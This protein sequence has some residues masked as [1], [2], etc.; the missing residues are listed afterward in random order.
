MIASE[1]KSASPDV[2]NDESPAVVTKEYD[3]VR[4]LEKTGHH[5]SLL[6]NGISVGVRFSGIPD[7]CGVHVEVVHVLDLRNARLGR[8][9]TGMKTHVL[10]SINKPL[11]VIFNDLSLTNQ[12]VDKS[13]RTLWGK[14]PLRM[15]APSKAAMRKKRTSMIHETRTVY[16][17]TNEVRPS[18]DLTWL[19]DGSRI[20]SINEFT[21]ARSS[22][23]RSALPEIKNGIDTEKWDALQRGTMTSFYALLGVS[24]ASIASLSIL[25]AII[26]QSWLFPVSGIL[27]IAS[28]LMTAYYSIIS[29]RQIGLFRTSLQ[30][31]SAELSS[32]GDTKRITETLKETH[33]H[34]TIINDLNF[35]IPTL[36]GSAVESLIEG[37][38]NDAV[39]YSSVVLDEC[40]R[41][42]PDGYI[43][44]DN[45]FVA[46]RG[47]SKF[48]GLF[49]YLGVHFEDG[50]EEAL[51]LA[52]SAISGHAESPLTGDEVV[53]HITG[54]SFALFNSGIL[55]PQLKDSIDD[56]LNS[57]S[58]EIYREHLDSALDD[59]DE[60]VVEKEV[61]S[62]IDD[63]IHGEI[64]STLE[65]IS[66]ADD[67]DSDDSEVQ[68][69]PPDVV[70]DDDEEPEDIPSEDE[71]VEEIPRRHRK[72]RESVQTT[73]G[74][75]VVEKLTGDHKKDIES[76]IQNAPE[77]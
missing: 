13:I 2:A 32:I 73:L 67:S 72:I 52:Y 20:L 18:Y 19:T 57:W 70:I 50:E 56:S 4:I 30:V 17:V 15:I 9:M 49:H 23:A 51:A 62:V 43:P 16:V 5:T 47:L 25:F 11:E 71:P 48:I 37:N 44:E 35:I 24:L 53:T 77:E 6:D 21:I 10:N 76:H 42:A 64:I 27:L 69:I 7:T 3:V 59:S 63:D 14:V 55:S 22:D 33:S 36:V 8:S 34:M 40:V 26:E 1:E 46:D 12:L 61:E 58:M 65:D 75:D 68:D 28:T 38:V 39:H 31:E 54:L 60:S 45:L 29:R 74:S 66:Q 41:L